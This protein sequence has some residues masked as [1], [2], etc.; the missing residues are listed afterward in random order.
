MASPPQ[1]A[2]PSPRRLSPFAESSGRASSVVMD[3]TGRLSARL[4]RFA[5]LLSIVAV[6]DLT[7]TMLCGLPLAYRG[8]N[9]LYA[10]V[11][12]SSLRALLVFAVV[13]SPRI[14]EHYPWM[15]GQAMVRTLRTKSRASI[16]DVA[17]HVLG[18]LTACPL[19]AL[20]TRPAVSLQRARTTVFR[21]ARS[22]DVEERGPQRLVHRRRVQPVATVEMAHCSGCIRLLRG[23]LRLLCRS[24]CPIC[25]RRRRVSSATGAARSSQAG[26][27]SRPIDERQRHLSPSFEHVEGSYTT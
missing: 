9:G 3:S 18:A 25:S 1:L 8:Q 11:T 27:L 24:L 7:W 6:A 17:G 22:A 16:D 14:R 2:P 19:T 5:R 12:W 10:A 13:N 26:E 15:I 23:V 20:A 4:P 21:A